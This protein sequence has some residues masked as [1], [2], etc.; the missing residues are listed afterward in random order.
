[1]HVHECVSALATP[2]LHVLRP[3]ES[4]PVNARLV[5]A[6]LKAALSLAETTLRPSFLRVP[7]HR[8]R[9]SVVTCTGKR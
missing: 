3:H 5:T 9:A 8:R 4:L 2:V 6:E 7:R 1:M